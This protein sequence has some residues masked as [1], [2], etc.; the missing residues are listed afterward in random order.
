MNSFLFI[1]F[2]RVKYWFSLTVAIVVKVL[3]YVQN[4]YVEILLG[5]CQKGSFE[6]DFFNSLN[7]SALM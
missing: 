5:P 4:M 7:L 3:G 2:M 1:H 6:I